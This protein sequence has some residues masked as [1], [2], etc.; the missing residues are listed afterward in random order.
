MGSSPRSDSLPGTS[1]GFQDADAYDQLMGRWS[2]RLAP[3]LIQFGGLFDGDSVIDV[4]CGT[5]SLTFALPEYA[6]VSSVKGIDLTN[7]YVEAARA[8]NQNPK[9]TFDLGDATALP[10]ADASFDRA[11]CMLVLHFIPDAA[12]AVAEM[13]RV[14]K[15]GGTITGAVWDNYSGQPFTRILWDIA[16]VLDPK[17]ERPYFRPLNGPDEMATVWRELGL[18]DVEQSSL[19]IRMDFASF[20]D[21]WTPFA[22]G[23]GPHGQ[24]VVRLSEIA[25]ETLKEHVRRAYVAN[26]PDGPRSMVAVAWACRGTVPE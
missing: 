5:G 6:N 22:S 24:Y 9:I 23:E 16:G 13:R 8:R 20:D 12:K 14:V 1:L 7:A 2:R 19:L 15:R 3:L 17:I 26:R 10:Y 4:G 25:R 11:F 18:R 21:Y